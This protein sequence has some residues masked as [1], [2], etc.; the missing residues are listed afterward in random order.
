MKGQVCDPDM[1][2]VQYLKN[3]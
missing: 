2:R 3:R 1:L